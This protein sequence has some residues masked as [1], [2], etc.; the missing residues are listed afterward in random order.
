M[1]QLDLSPQA[2]IDLRDIW[3]YIA[4]HRPEAADRILEAIWKQARQLAAFPLMGRSREELSPG[5]RS[6]PVKKYIIYYRP[7]SEGIAIARVLHGARDHPGL[8]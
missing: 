1:R 6:F 8:L 4:E 5:L 7:T 2:E 3:V